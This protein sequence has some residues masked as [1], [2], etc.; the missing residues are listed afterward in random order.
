MKHENEAKYQNQV[1]PD[2]QQ[3]PGGILVYYADGEEEITY[4]N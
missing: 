3:A 4:V 1:F 2:D